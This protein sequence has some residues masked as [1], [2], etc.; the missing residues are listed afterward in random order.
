MGR[1]GDDL[2]PLDSFDDRWKECAARRLD[3]F[4][5]AMK[6]YL[7]ARLF[8]NWIAYQGQGLRTI[9]EWL[10]TC[11]AVVGH[12]LLRH[13]RDAESILDTSAFI[14]AVRSADLIL[15]HVLD[16]ASFAKQAAAIEEF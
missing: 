6:N 1:V 3:W 14:E 15:L 11:A 2:A 13:A 4:N 5:A 7:G 16:S 8:A 9:V 10:R 12:E